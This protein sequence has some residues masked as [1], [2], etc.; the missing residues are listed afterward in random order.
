M[1]QL[2]AAIQDSDTEIHPVADGLHV[3]GLDENAPL[4]G[5]TEHN[6]Y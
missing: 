5:Y 1:M 3:Q 2:M 6:L 4:F